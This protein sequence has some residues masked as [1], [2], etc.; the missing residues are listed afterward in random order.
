[1]KMKEIID[2]VSEVYREE[3]G[4]ER[5]LHDELVSVTKSIL[6]ADYH[7]GE[8][9][10]FAEYNRLK[11]KMKSLQYELDMKKQYCDGISCAREILM[12]LAYNA[13]VK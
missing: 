7:S 4:K 13:E 1:M 8:N 9:I 3:L 12:D 10:S 5:E 2:R 6:D 11:D